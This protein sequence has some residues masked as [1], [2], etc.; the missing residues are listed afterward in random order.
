MEKILHMVLMFVFQIA[1]V[2]AEETCGVP[3]TTRY[4][5]RKNPKSPHA[6]IIKGIESKQLKWPWMVVITKRNVSSTHCT[7]FLI[8]RTHVLTAGHCFMR[9][10]SPDK[11]TIVIGNVKIQNGKKYYIS[12]I[13]VH[14]GY[15]DS[16]FYDDIALVKL[17]RKVRFEGFKPICLPDK[18]LSTR[19]LTG[20]FATAA[21]W[22]LTSLTLFAKTSDVLMQLNKVPIISNENCTKILNKKSMSFSRQF[23]FNITSGLLCTGVSSPGQNACKGDSGGPLMF[24][25]RGRWYAIGVFSFMYNCGSTGNPS[26]YTR[27][28]E[29][30]R[31][32]HQHV[33]RDN[34]ST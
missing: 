9:S 5:Y 3:G 21:G 20:L 17:K 11:Y 1:I 8:D 12:R 15:N 22:G 7:G 33:D 19:D 30:L 31:W 28:S 10:R 16:F 14:K 27:I 2:H 6:S 23:P 29:Y 25:D 26:G 32:I 24:S 4:V 18:K 34:N 13:N